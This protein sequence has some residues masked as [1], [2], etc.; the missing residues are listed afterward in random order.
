MQAHT[1]GEDYIPQQ[2]KKKRIQKRLFN[3]PKKKLRQ[4]TSKKATGLMVRLSSND[5]SLLN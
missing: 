1:N 5:T 4:H 3:R 2:T